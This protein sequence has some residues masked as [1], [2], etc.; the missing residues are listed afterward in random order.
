LQG[1]K[2]RDSY[3]AKGQDVAAEQ[4]YDRLQGIGPFSGRYCVS[5]P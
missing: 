5:R 3:H 2:G 1:D 4:G